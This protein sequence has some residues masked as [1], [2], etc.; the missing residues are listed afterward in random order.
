M[1]QTSISRLPGLGDTEHEC[2]QSFL[3]S[4]TRVCESVNQRLMDQHDLSLV[5]ILL[6]DLLTKSDC[7]SARMGEL[8]QS[9]TLIPSRVTARIS[10]LESRSLVFRSADR[11]DRRSV[12]ATITREGRAYGQRAMRTYARAVRELYLNPLSRNQMTAVSDSC[13]RVNAALP[14]APRWFDSV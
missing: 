1:N 7:G 3:Y 13:R 9:L 12:R 2:W 6:L 11:D 14:E 4:S 8:A 5:D 10:R